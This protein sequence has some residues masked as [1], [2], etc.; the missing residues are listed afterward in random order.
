MSYDYAIISRPVLKGDMEVAKLK[1]SFCML[2][3]AAFCASA[4]AQWWPIPDYTKPGVEK[5]CSQCV[6]PNKGLLTPGW[7]DP[8]QRYVGRFLSSEY[9]S[10]WQQPFR[11]VRADGMKLS[12][13]GKRLYL[14]FGSA[15]AVYDASRFIQ[16]LDAH[17]AMVP[18]SQLPASPTAG[19]RQ[20]DPLEVFLQ[21]NRYFYAEDNGSGW[22][23]PII[24]GQDRLFDWD[25]DDRGN[26]YMAYS[27]F[28]WGIAR[29]DGGN[30]GLLPSY[31]EPT[32]LA[33]TP[34]LIKWVKDGGSYYV[35]VGRWGLDSSQVFL[36]PNQGNPVAQP[37]LARGIVNLAR[38]GQNRV[39]VIDNL[40]RGLSIYDTHSLVS[41]GQ[42][43]ATFSAAGSNA[44][45]VDVAW[46]GTRFWAASYTNAL[47]GTLSSFTPD[48][49][50]QTY[51]RADYPL[52][53]GLM[54]QP[55]SLQYGSGY[56]SVMTNDDAG[57]AL[58][59]FKVS[60][61]VPVEI[62]VPSVT[63]YYLPPAGYA[64][65]PHN[66]F[67]GVLPFQY[68]GSM[69]LIASSHSLGDVYQIRSDDGL[70]VSRSQNTV[71]GTNP[72]TPARDAGTV[73]Y[74]DTVQFQAALSSGGTGTAITWDYGDGTSNSGAVGTPVSHAYRGLTSQ[75]IASG[76]TVKATN[77]ATGVVGSTSLTFTPPTIRFGIGG[78]SPRYLLA[79]PNASSPAAIVTSDN[80][81][82]ASDGDASGHTTEWRIGA[83]T[84]EISSPSFLPK[85]M[86]PTSATPVGACGDHAMQLIAHYGTLSA[87][88]PGYAVTLPAVNGSTTFGYSVK[89]FSPAVDASLDT[90]TGKIK[91]VSNSRAATQISTFPVTY[92]WEVIEPTGTP[93]SGAPVAGATASTIDAIP[94]YYVD[95]SVFS[96]SGRR[97]RLTLT[98]DDGGVCSGV[99][100]NPATPTGRTTSNA[101][102]S[103]PLVPPDAQINGTCTGNNCQFSISSPTN[104]MTS[105]G[106]TVSWSAPGGTPSS[107][108]GSTFSPTFTTK[109][110]YAVTAVVTNKIGLSSGPATNPLLTKSVTITQDAS[111]CSPLVPDQ[112]VFLSAS[113]T[114][115]T[116]GTTCSVAFEVDYWGYSTSC[117]TH[118]YQWTFDGSS[119]AS[120]QFVTKSLATG[121]HTASCVVSNGAQTVTLSLTVNVTATTVQPPPPPPPPP[122]SGCNALSANS[123]V[124]VAF[125]GPT[126]GCTSAATNCT[127]NEQIQF[128]VSYWNYNS[129]CA[130]HSYSWQFDDGA[131]A[132]GQAVYHAFATAGNHTASCVVNNGTQTVTVSTTVAVATGTTPPTP[133]TPS[134]GT[135]VKDQN[136]FLNTA[137]TSCNVGSTCSVAL[138]IDFWGYSNSCATHTYQWSFDDGS[139][140][141][142]QY[143]TKSFSSGSHTATCLV[144]NGSQTLTLSSTFTVT[145]GTPA[146]PA[147][148]V[149]VAVD[150]LG[151]GMYKFT[152]TVKSGTVTK[153]VWDFGDGSTTTVSDSRSVTNTYTKPGHYTVTLTAQ[154]SGQS[155]VVTTVV[156]V[157]AV[158]RS[159]AARH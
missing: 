47:T 12:P 99:V 101:A 105:D 49:S 137:G 55:M 22:T 83:N 117:A 26:I 20:G 29:D 133:P 132:S 122:Q 45:F 147:P 33:S 92:L 159:R 86:S 91:F 142:G 28:G 16:R 72:S 8:V 60:T 118:T 143:V 107:G 103:A 97:A 127:T 75:Q 121:S 21:V 65:P 84:A 61:G 125:S 158:S 90:A 48:P 119:T 140:A 39:A 80:F 114:S 154:S 69:Y 157:S 96:V 124:F 15:I 113:G 24:D 4:F 38:D 34:T 36:V 56:L 102:V 11:T 44:L 67:S 85:F 110:T 120:G 51:T 88:D 71:G 106:W 23:C 70:V 89:A 66:V 95:P 155:A 109:G 42:P 130:T 108:T 87:S 148:V 104:V 53:N 13:D 77:P 35:F 129:G 43:L 64:R 14:K 25:V 136:V 10:D 111:L 115:C 135:L 93:V 156:D 112:N 52:R 138:S 68:N 73:F 27:I 30:G 18:I 63:S 37:P 41:N 128:N 94:A 134:C 126:S 9:V 123:N 153:F 17:E 5:P 74:G 54:A 79:L 82:D 50:R 7:A 131:T 59:L 141:S 76:V 145:G 149:T 81:F 46:D 98:M 62:A 116:T 139:T 146:T 2:V 144:S 78:S 57:T 6:Y 3:V 31:Q 58:H 19:S 100:T 32:S 152:P 1:I 151:A 40:T 150:Y